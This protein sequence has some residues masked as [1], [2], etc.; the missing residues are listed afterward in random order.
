MVRCSRVLLSLISLFPVAASAC[1]DDAAE[2][3][4]RQDNFSAICQSSE[5]CDSPL[6]CICG[7]CT[8]ANCLGVGCVVESSIC[9]PPNADGFSPRCDNE[10]PQVDSICAATCNTT[11]DCPTGLRCLMQVC[12]GTNQ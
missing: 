10:V 6:D 2:P 7:I 11:D 5:D 9:I 1:G 12:G 4:G 8:S 3:S